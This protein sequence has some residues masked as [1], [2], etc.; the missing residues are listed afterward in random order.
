[1]S[2]K[3]RVRFA[4]SPTGALHIGGVR[5]ALFNYLF[6]KSQ[7]GDFLLRIE[8]TDQTRYVPSAEEYINKSLEW[9]GI[10]PDEGVRQ[11]GDYGPYRQSERKEIYAKYARQLVADKKAYYAFDTAEELDEMRRNLEASGS[12]VRH[13]NFLT[14]GKMKNSFTLSEDEVQK[15]LAAGEPYVIRFNIPKDRI[16]EMH[17]II[18]GTVKVNTNELDDKVLFKSDGFPTYHLANVT[19]DYSMKISHV[20]RGEEWLPSLPLHVL[21]YEALGWE[22]DMPQF[23]H[24]PLIL[25]PNGKGKLSK[26]DG[27]KMGFPVYP[28]EWTEP[29]TN[30]TAAGFRDDGYLKEAFINLIALLGWSPG[31]NEEVFDMENLIKVFDIRKVNKSGAK[32]S[33]DKAKW[34]NEQYIRTYDIDALTELYL[35]LFEARNITVERSYLTKVLGLMRERISLLPDL[36]DEAGF[37]FKT[38]EE[39]NAKGVKKHWKV[40]ISEH[41]LKITVLL[42]KINPEEFTAENIKET[43]S[44]YIKSNEL[45]FGKILNPIRLLITGTG[46]GPDLFEIIVTIGKDEAILRLEKGMAVLS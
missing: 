41:V 7:G 17:D 45:G 46:G 24:L 39:Y 1:M 14:R 38:P 42:K 31:T 3:I 29:G 15:R 12:S 22:K 26:R 2:K 44:T 20:I 37:F 30:D 35:P 6:A 8:D 40:G 34:F 11:G 10:T 33:P 5:T 13:Y 36:F 21:L 18:R 27:E 4:P 19:D 25:K 9:C 32:F 23:A 43:I 28:L 16:V